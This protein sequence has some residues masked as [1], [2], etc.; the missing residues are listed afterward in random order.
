MC[1]RVHICFILFHVSPDIMTLKRK[2]EVELEE[3][4]A[5]APKGLTYTV[6]R[7]GGLTDG[8]AIGPKGTCGRRGVRT[9]LRATKNERPK[10]SSDRVYPIFWY[11]DEWRSD[12]C[13]Q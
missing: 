7:P 6:V 1:A 9:G 2:G 11:F 5:N 12:P 10:G 3:I 13:V 4:Y 8:A